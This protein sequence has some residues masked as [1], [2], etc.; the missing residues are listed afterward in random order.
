MSV[1][2]GEMGAKRVNGLTI[3]SEHEVVFDG[4]PASCVSPFDGHIEERT[5]VFGQD[6]PIGQLYRAARVVEVAEQ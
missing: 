1:I 4:Q 3:D 5:P 2:R 6:K